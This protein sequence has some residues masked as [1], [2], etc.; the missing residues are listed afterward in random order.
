MSIRPLELMPMSVT[1]LE[2]TGLRSS[3]RRET[4]RSFSDEGQRCEVVCD[5]GCHSERRMPSFYSLLGEEISSESRSV[6]GGTAGQ[7]SLPSQ[8][9]YSAGHPDVLLVPAAQDP[10]SG[11]AKLLVHQG[12]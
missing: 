4:I 11:E 7:N 10:A 3:P 5:I 6:G 2:D 1:T 8:Y 9:L 12:E